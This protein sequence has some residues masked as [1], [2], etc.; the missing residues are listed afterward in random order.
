MSGNVEFMFVFG[1]VDVD[2]IWQIAATDVSG[3]SQWR[4][5]ARLRIIGRDNKDL[6]VMQ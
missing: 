1:A 5:K 3:V 2:A 6:R 4:Q